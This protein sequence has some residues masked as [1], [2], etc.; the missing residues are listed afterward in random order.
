LFHRQHDRALAAEQR[1][2]QYAHLLR[3]LNEGCP[4]ALAEAL[5]EQWWSTLASRDLQ[6]E[7]A[8]DR[9]ILAS[10]WPSFVES[11]PGPA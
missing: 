7:I 4:S 6:S 11:R 8:M 9:G 2:G 10:V 3:S 5:V 1:A